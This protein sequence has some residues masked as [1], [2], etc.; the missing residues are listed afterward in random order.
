MPTVKA[1]K[2]T[3]SDVKQQPKILKPTDE[4]KQS[5]TQASLR[6]RITLT[7]TTGELDSAERKL[8]R[9]KKFNVPLSGDDAKDQR[10]IRFVSKSKV[11]CRF[12]YSL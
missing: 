1:K 4:T 3:A 6:A 7:S 9:A 11:A 2:T 5:P 8:E 12:A 10:A